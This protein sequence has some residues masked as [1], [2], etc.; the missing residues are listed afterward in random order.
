[1]PLQHCGDCGGLPPSPTG[2]SSSFGKH[3]I[4]LESDWFVQRLHLPGELKMLMVE[5]ISSASSA[6][7]WVLKGSRGTC[8][9]YPPHCSCA[10]AKLEPALELLHCGF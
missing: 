6:W 2:F 4:Q 3:Q 1:M 10:A 7:S 9:G 5:H 8:L